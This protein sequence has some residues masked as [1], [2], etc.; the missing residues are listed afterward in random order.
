MADTHRTPTTPPAVVI[1]DVN[2]T[3]S[4][5]SP[6]A[7]SF[8][9]AGLG[10]NALE[11]W[12][13]GLLRD[14]F[15]LTSVGVNPRFADLASEALRVRLAAARTNG[16][17][18]GVD[19]ESAVREVMS[20]FSALSVHPDVVDG[21]HALRG[22]GVRLVTLS[23]GSTA[24][25]QGLLERAG[26]TGAFEAL[27]SVEDAAAW[28]PHPASYA[29]ALDTCGVSAGDAMLVA[30]HPWDIDGAAR[31]GLRTGW[32]NRKGA[33]YPGYFTAAEIEAADLVE[34]ARAL[35]LPTLA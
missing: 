17:D 7:E 35:Q 16:G 5:L 20:S 27:M 8:E 31:A 10:S 9:R 25:A 33:R 18:A 1:F 32:L 19:M 26:L 14:G 28:K 21:V 23:N 3:L 24:V 34:L 13:A 15:A 11:P 12:F 4:D 29:Y 30:V 6:L 22:L 2:E